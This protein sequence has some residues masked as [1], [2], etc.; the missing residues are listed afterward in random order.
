MNICSFVLFVIVGN[1]FKVFS[2]FSNEHVFLSNGNEKILNEGFNVSMVVFKC[3][4]VKFI[5][6]SKLV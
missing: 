3:S 1:N 4:V 5:S 6:I 2:K